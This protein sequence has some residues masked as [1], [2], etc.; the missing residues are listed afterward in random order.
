MLRAL[1]SW[2]TPK[3]KAE[4]LVDSAIRYN[5]RIRRRVARAMAQAAA[6][7]TRDEIESLR[8]SLTAVSLRAAQAAHYGRG[9]GDDIA[10]WPLLDKPS[11]VAAPGDFRNRKVRLRLPAGTGGTTGVPLK[12]WRSLECVVA[13]QAFLDRLLAPHGLSMRQSRIAILRGDRVKDTQDQAPPY[14]AVSHRGMRLTLSSAHLNPATLSWYAAA[15]REFSPA[16]LWVY[17]SAVQNLLRLC[18]EKNI[19][20]EVPVIL[21]SSEMMPP[22]LHRA[23]EQQ[24]H[25]R[26]INYYGQ[27]ERVCLAV[28]TVP[29]E[30]RFVPDYGRVELLPLPQQS[31]AGHGAAEIVATNYW[32]TAMPLVRYRTGD[33]LALPQHP[34][35]H[36]LSEIALG[37][38]PFEA[39]LGREGEYLLTRAGM[40]I[41]GLNQIPRELE[42]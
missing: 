18:Q 4:G 19:D 10:A 41:I 25:C 23:L 11:L 16:V 8:D 38:R 39:V 6:C 2:A 5:A 36:V 27:A 28:S 17:P 26:V 7:T 9:R 22:A 21:A 32:N 29:G 15:L 34:D 24:F 42:H 3:A 40:R 14:G 13:E 12:I 20:L 30:F 33:S 37:L 31:G 35:T 1:L